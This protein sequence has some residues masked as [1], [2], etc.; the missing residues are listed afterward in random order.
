MILAACG[1]TPGVAP[2]AA[3]SAAVQQAQPTTQP[4][5]APSVLALSGNGDKVTPIT[6]Q[7]GNYNVTWTASGTADDNFQIIIHGA[8][9]GEDLIAN[10]TLNN[11]YS[12]DRP[13]G[14]TFFAASGG[15]EYTLAV[16]G[17]FAWTI[18]FSPVP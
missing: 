18:S 14:Q 6:V 10:A 8:N 12:S 5:P 9:G 17:P 2:S 4:T 1:E 3:A 13:T 16:K 7:N 11:P 15:T